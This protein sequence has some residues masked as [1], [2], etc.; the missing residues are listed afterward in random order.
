MEAYRGLK[1]GMTESEVIAAWG[2][3]TNKKTSPEFAS[4]KREMWFYQREDEGKE[5]RLVFEMST[6]REVYMDQELTDL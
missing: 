3:P 2:E 6:L 5:D 4:R 1:I